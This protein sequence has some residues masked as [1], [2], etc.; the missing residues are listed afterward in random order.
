VPARGK[1][2]YLI[3]NSLTW[4]TLPELLDGDVDYHV[5]CGKS[6]PFI[7][8]HPQSPCIESSTLWPKA[9]SENQYDIVSV[10]PHYG[11]TLTEDV[12]VISEWVKLQS[13]AVF[14]IHT[15]WAEHSSR[16]R[17][18]ES[19]DINGPLAH[20][21][22]YVNALIHEL[23]TRFP[24]R[25]FRATQATVALDHIAKDIENG[26][27]PMSEVKDLYRD[28]IHMTH[29]HGRYLMHNLMRDALGQPPSLT[30]FADGESAMGNMNP[31]WVAYLDTIIESH[32]LPKLAAT[33]A[34]D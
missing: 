18:F 15:G 2:Y 10:Q 17:E 34:M 21:Q 3:G 13:N 16:S 6:L 27:A 32:R 31:D 23:E 7:Y 26:A 5:D 25:V 9:L 12:H 24:K 1:R 30:A 28:E 29:S 11:S 8:N 22:A 19:T 4:D 20:S 33:P 14:V